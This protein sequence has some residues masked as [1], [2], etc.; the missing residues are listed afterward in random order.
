MTFPFL[1]LWSEW[2][3][4]ALRVFV[5]ALFLAHGLP[6]LKNLK[7]TGEWFQS[8]G[9]K[10]R[11]FWG[12]VAALAEFFG[13]MA[14][15]LGFFTQV[16]A[17][18]LALQFLVILAWRLKRRD[19]FVGGWELDLVVLGALFALLTLGGGAYALDYWL[20]F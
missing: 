10:P 14:L 8:V 1:L 5:G 7:G 2:A 20:R 9:F 11:F 12:T 15:I 19:S 4:F 6:K 18:I 17:A 16:A 3:I 13:G